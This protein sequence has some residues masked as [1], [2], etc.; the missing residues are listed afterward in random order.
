[1]SQNQPKNVSVDAK[2]VIIKT[3]AQVFAETSENQRIVLLTDHGIFAGRPQ[4]P[5]MFD[6]LKQKMNE[7]IEERLQNLREQQ[8]EKAEGVSTQVTG[9]DAI[10][11]RDAEFIPYSATQT[12]FSY[13][14]VFVLLDAVIG[15]AVTERI[16]TSV[17]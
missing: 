7:S 12:R 17:G 14:Q 1:M 5:S 16:T 11:L 10:E 8:P 13:S 6:N 15:V 4:E 9:G 3:M 2:A